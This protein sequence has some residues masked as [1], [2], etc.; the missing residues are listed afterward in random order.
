METV[1]LETK[2][3]EISKLP[4]GKYADLLKAIKKL[5]TQIGDVTN[6]NNDEI[7]AKLP[8]MMG[9]AMP[10]F[11]EIIKIGANLTEE[12]AQALSLDE[13]V[14]IVIA[15]AKVNKF[16]DLWEKA[17][18]AIARFQTMK[19]EVKVTTGLK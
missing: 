19:K 15:I 1:K 4:L 17:K 12:E 10:D 8:F 5:P 13:A 18:K 2:T 14:E 9:E 3:L 16:A 7:I 6:L 11:I